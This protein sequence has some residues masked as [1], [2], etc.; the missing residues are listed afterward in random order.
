MNTTELIGAVVT[1]ILFLAVQFKMF[2]GLQEKTDSAAKALEGIRAAFIGDSTEVRKSLSDL[3]K[4]VYKIETDV[5]KLAASFDAR[6]LQIDERH[7]NAETDMED[8]KGSAHRHG[9]D[10]ANIK[11]WQSGTEERLKGIDARTSQMELRMTEIR[12]SHGAD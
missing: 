2:G 8:L 12:N 6:N 9:V 10:I 5:A 11:A 4:S 1:V 7:H 3:S